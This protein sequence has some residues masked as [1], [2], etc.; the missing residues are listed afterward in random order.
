MMSVVRISTYDGEGHPVGDI[1]IP[2]ENVHP[3]LIAHAEKG[4]DELA[5]VRDLVDPD[6]ENENYD[7]DLWAKPAEVRGDLDGRPRGR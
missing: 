1:H 6:H 3:W 4:A 7:W 2:L 5:D